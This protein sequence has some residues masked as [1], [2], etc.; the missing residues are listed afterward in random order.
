[1]RVI[2]ALRLF[3]KEHAV[4]GI[5]GESGVGKTKG[6][7]VDINVDRLHPVLKNII[8]FH[9][10]NGTLPPTR[11][12]EVLSRNRDDSTSIEGTADCRLYW[13][14]VE[15]TLPVAFWETRHEVEA[16]LSQEALDAF[17]ASI[18]HR[19]GAAYI[20]ACEQFAREMPLPPTRAIRY[21]PPGRRGAKAA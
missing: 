21:V 2:L 16:V 6:T 5:E 1:M 11:K 9:T 4:F 20:E 15:T 14:L 7:L 12:G 13:C 3:K 10:C 17:A 19:S 8:D 18:R